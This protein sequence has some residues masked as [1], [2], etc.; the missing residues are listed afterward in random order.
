MQRELDQRDAE[1]AR[2][3]EELG[4]PTQLKADKQLEAENA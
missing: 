1:I 4:R 3:R 2:L